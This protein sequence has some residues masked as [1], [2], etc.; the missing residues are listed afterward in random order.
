MQFCTS[1]QFLAIFLEIIFL[2]IF[3]RLEKVVGLLPTD[4][5]IASFLTFASFAKSSH[6]LIYV[7]ASSAVGGASNAMGGVM[8]SMAF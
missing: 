5:F 6:L 8:V 7:S 3:V 4:G 2:T 1:N